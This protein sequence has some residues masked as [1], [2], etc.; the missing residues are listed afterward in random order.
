MKKNKTNKINYRTLQYAVAVIFAELF[1]R[2]NCATKL[3]E[4]PKPAA[5]EL[6]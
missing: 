2:T 1:S 3:T 4:K 6:V 5:L